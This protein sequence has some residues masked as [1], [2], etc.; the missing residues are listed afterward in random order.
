MK[1]CTLIKVGEQLPVTESSI[2]ASGSK[3]LELQLQTIKKQD[4]LC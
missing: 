2:R 1:I 3:G 4:T